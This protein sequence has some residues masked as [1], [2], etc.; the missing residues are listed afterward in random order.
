MFH[1]LS[2]CHDLSRVSVYVNELFKLFFV[3]LVIFQI[4]PTEK[5]IINTNRSTA[6]FGI[7]RISLEESFFV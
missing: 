1:I 5:S 3:F 6:V 2:C 4:T 7:N